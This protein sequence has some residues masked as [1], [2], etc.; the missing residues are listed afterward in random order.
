MTIRDPQHKLEHY[1]VL[2]YL[3]GD[4]LREHTGYLGRRERLPLRPLTTP[5]REDGI[6]A[7]LPR[8]IPKPKAME[9][10]KNAW[11]LATTWRLIDER[12]STRQDPARDQAL[13]RRLVRSINASLMEDMR[14]QTEDAGE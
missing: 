4:P 10:H 3:R 7:D 8:A 2:G 13:I 14:R 12:F 11:I 9:P 6:S 5:T 1:L